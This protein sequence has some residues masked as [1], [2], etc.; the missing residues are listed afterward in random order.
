MASNIVTLTRGFANTDFTDEVK[1]GSVDDSLVSGV[2][3][4]INALNASLSGGTDD[5]LGAFFADQNGNSFTKIVG[6][7]IVTTEVTEL[8]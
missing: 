1:L 4:K 8:S 5:G 6:A 2:K 3:T 7:K